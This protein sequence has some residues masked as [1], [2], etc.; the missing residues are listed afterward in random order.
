MTVALCHVTRSQCMKPPA[1][2]RMN[3]ITYIVTL[4]VLV[5]AI[6]T[7][8]YEVV[9]KP[10]LDYLRYNFGIVSLFSRFRTPRRLGRGTL[11]AFLAT[12]EAV[13]LQV[14]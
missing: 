12:V 3:P 9:L 2:S 10:T 8:L 11:V 13:T 7:L 1:T 14:R 5:L 4:V 6:L